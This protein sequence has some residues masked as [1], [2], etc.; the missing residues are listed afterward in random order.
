MSVCQWDHM[1]NNV[2]IKDWGI[3][4]TAWSESFVFLEK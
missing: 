2:M 4:Q 1:E 3:R